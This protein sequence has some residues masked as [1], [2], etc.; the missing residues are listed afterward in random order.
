MRSPEA[1]RAHKHGYAKE[2]A[3]PV[4]FYDEDQCFHDKSHFSR[5]SKLS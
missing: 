5:K 2:K 4:K 1:E 3:K